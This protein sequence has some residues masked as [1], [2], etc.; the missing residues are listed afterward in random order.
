LR[1]ANAWTVWALRSLRAVMNLQE[2]GLLS[3]LRGRCVGIGK[4]GVCCLTYEK[5]AAHEPLLS[6]LSL[7]Q[8]VPHRVLPP[9]TTPRSSHRFG[10]RNYATRLFLSA[11][12]IRQTRQSRDGNSHLLARESSRPTVTR[13]HLGEDERALLNSV[14][15]VPGLIGSCVSAHT[16]TDR[17]LRRLPQPMTC[18]IMRRNPLCVKI[19]LRP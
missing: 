10:T 12:A 19:R 5:G 6:S 1:F 11:Y 3:G 14:Y 2:W 18:A 4:E 9:P 7:R 17:F 13:W 16:G 8:N 15:D